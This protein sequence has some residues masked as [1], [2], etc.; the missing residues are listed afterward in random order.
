M[1]EHPYAGVAAALAGT[2]FS[3]VRYVERTASTNA[4]A[5]DLL[6]DAR[7]A[8]RTLVAEHQTLGKGRKGRTWVAGAGTSLLFTTVLP[9]PVATATLWIVPFWA[10]L[11]IGGAL[12]R[13]GV[14]A[15]LHWPNDLL[16][17]S[18]KVGGILCVSRV[19]GERASV[20]VGAG[21]NVHRRAGAEQNIEPPPAF[22]DDVAPVDRASLL[23]SILQGY[24][25]E[26]GAL[27]DPGRIVRAWEKAAELPGRRYRILK[28]GT[29]TPFEATALALA[30][31]GGLVVARDDGARETISLADARALR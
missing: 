24:A 8:G 9:E 13:H 28:D 20:G 5:A 10:A 15:T 19:S 14:A 21:I 18:R 25:S 27:A 16:I 1:H 6:G 11:A 26:L 7:F 12:E 3:D 2:P 29:Q 30:N 31:G 22:C 4:D 17:E 23:L